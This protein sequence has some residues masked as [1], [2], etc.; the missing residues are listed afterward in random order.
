MRRRNYEESGAR[1]ARPKRWRERTRRLRPKILGAVVFLTALTTL[2]LNLDRIVGW[3]ENEP[4]AVGDARD[5]KT[6]RGPVAQDLGEDADGVTVQD[7]SATRDSTVDRPNR[8]EGRSPLESL[9]ATLRMLEPVVP[10]AGEQ[11]VTSARAK[12]PVLLGDTRDQM[13]ARNGVRR[14]LELEER[15]V[16]SRLTQVYGFANDVFL[17]LMVNRRNRGRTASVRLS[18]EQSVTYGVEV[19]VLGEGRALV[20]VCVSEGD[21]T[22]LSEPAGGAREVFG[23]YRDCGENH[24]VL[25]GIPISRIGR[26]ES[27][28]L[29]FG[30]IEVN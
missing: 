20:L 17:E 5:D 4:Q 8:G 7:R 24:P 9:G 28:T 3:F 29:D 11:G 12:A 27:R 19:Q 22:R 1:A 25:V 13:R 30:V 21:A 10:L 26:W 2:I 15:Q 23:F 16:L 14:M 18:G 6:Q